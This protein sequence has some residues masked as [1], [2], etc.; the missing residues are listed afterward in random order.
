MQ[1]NHKGPYKG[2]T[3]G[4]KVVLGHVKMKASVGPMQ[5]RSHK[6]RNVDNLQKLKKARK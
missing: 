2:E 6:S 1:Y 3:K 5:A 4:F